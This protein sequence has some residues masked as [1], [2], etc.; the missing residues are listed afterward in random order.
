M[1][2]VLRCAITVVLAF[3][4]FQAFAQGTYPQ[5]APSDQRSGAFAFTHATIYQNW[6]QKLDDATLLIR[7]GHVEACGTGIAIPKDAVVTDCSG[8]TI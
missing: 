3:S 1:N 6:N 8:K 5:P 7:D 4:A 2:T